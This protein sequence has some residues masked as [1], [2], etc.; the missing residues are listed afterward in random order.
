[1]TAHTRKNGRRL[2]GG[3]AALGALAAFALTPSLLATPASALSPL[4]PPPVTSTRSISFTDGRGLLGEG[5]GCT[6]S[7][8]AVDWLTQ[9]AKMARLGYTVQPNL[10]PAY[11]DE[12][13][14]KPTGRKCSGVNGSH[15][16]M[17]LA[18][19]TA[20]RD[21][22]G[23]QPQ[24]SGLKY[25]VMTSLTRDLQV[26][27]ACGA[28]DWM[29]A[30]GFNRFAGMFAPAAPTNQNLTDEIV[31]QV[32]QPCGFIK[33]RTYGGVTVTKY[34]PLRTDGTRMAVNVRGKLNP[35]GYYRTLSVNGG[36]CPLTW[37]CTSGS[38]RTYMKPAL[39]IRDLTD[40]PADSH[41]IVQAYRLVQGNQPGLWN[42][43]GPVETHATYAAETYCANDYDEVVAAAAA[44]GW[45]NNNPQSVLETWGWRAP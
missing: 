42:C 37:Q 10:V 20:N 29:L 30:H 28:R 16:Y 33:A 23:G 2:G 6:L 40:A 36:S 39:L 17:S 32:I 26:E 22:Y 9:A 27:E 34:Q 11:V 14:R 21:L 35:V 18:D 24:T 38:K 15:I 31:T 13:A 44:L 5:V 25:R 12:G 45:V 41:M 43:D 3:L 4:P 7:P 19:A 1:M 8:L